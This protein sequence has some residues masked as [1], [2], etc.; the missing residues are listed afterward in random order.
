MNSVMS[1]KWGLPSVK[2]VIQ[3]VWWCSTVLALYGQLPAKGSPEKIVHSESVAT[4][5]VRSSSLLGPGDVLSIKAEEAEELN[6]PAI[7]VDNS[8]VLSLPVVGRIAVAGM[9]VETLEAELVNRLRSY[10]KR[11]AVTVS[12]VEYHSQPVS[13]LGSVANP[14]VHQVQG[15]KTL[16]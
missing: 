4:S 13:V 16:A 5:G 6:S 10:V 8:G 1:A 9:N 7:R 3:S 2:R 11:P 15:H 14:G 12:V